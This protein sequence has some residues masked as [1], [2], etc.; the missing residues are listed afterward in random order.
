MIIYQLYFGLVSA[1]GSLSVLFSPLDTQQPITSF[2]K[3]SQQ[4]ILPS[5]V[6]HEHSRAEG[7]G[8]ARAAA[9]TYNIVWS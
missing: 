9:T 2:C 8:G 4:Q 3:M 7:P 6:T 5:S 1:S